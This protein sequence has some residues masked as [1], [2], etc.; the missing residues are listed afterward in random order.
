[1]VLSHWGSGLV[2]VFSFVQSPSLV[3]PVRSNQELCV[4]VAALYPAAAVAVQVCL[5]ALCALYASWQSRPGSTNLELM[6]WLAA[7]FQ[8]PV[9]MLLMRLVIG[10]GVASVMQGSTTT[11]LIKGL[12]MLALMECVCLAFL[13]QPLAE[14][15]WQSRLE[16]MHNL[17]P[18]P[19]AKRHKVRDME[20]VAL[21]R[22][23]CDVWCPITLEGNTCSPTRKRD[24][25]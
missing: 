21:Q 13:L 14:A 2:L 17:P 15:L 10:D 16:A 22:C 6:T 4:L 24:E 19:T 23:G 25:D 20:L 9:P 18:L 12:A 1:M 11:I 7:V 5:K 3:K 8:L